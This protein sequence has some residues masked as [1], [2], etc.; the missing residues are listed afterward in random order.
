M[1]RKSATSSI[2]VLSFEFLLWERKEERR[3]KGREKKEKGR[4][5][6]EEVRKLDG[7]GGG[8]GRGNKEKL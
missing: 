1:N 5:K 7:G 8:E 4:R 2:N 3:E 6:K